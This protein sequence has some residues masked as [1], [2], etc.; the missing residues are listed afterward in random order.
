MEKV[1][2]F[3]HTKGQNK[4]INSVKGL[5]RILSSSIQVPLHSAI[6]RSG[7][8]QLELFIGQGTHRLELL[9]QM[10]KFVQSSA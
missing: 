6:I 7:T 9:H 3:N 5:S 10:I 1:I 2:S 8:W 4:V